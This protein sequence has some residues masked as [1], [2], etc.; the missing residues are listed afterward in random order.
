MP[1]GAGQQ[2]NPHTERLEADDLD[3][4]PNRETPKKMVTEMAGSGRSGQTAVGGVGAA[5][6]M[7]RGGQMKWLLPD[8]QDKDSIR[9]DNH[10]DDTN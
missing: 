4:R 2:R 5:A 3:N 1:E 9:I 8:G 7:H 10:N 6:E